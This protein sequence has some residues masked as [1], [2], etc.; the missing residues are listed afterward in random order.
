MESL[1]R[2]CIAYFFGLLSLPGSSPRSASADAI[3]MSPAQLVP[4]G[5][6]PLDMLLEDLD[7]DG[8]PDVVVTNVGVDESSIG[9][10]V[11][12]N[13]GSA[14]FASPVRYLV[15]TFTRTV[16][17]GD[18]DDDG[19]ADVAVGLI[20]E[21]APLAVL[22][23]AGDGT[24]GAPVFAGVGGGDGPEASHALD[25][26][27]DGDLD[28]VHG[29]AGFGVAAVFLNS[30]D[31]TFAAPDLYLSAN[32]A[33]TSD[34]AVAD[35]DGDADPDL[36]V[37]RTL[38]PDPPAILLNRGDGTFDPPAPFH[39]ETFAHLAIAAADVDRDGDQDLVLVAEGNRIDVFLNDGAGAFA[40]P[41]PYPLEA[42]TGL[43]VRIA[44]A[45]LD[46]DGAPEALFPSR[47][48][49][50][51]RVLRNDGA[52]AFA[53]PDQYF[54]GSEPITPRAADLDADG[55]RDVVATGFTTHQVVVLLNELGASTGIEEVAAVAGL[56]LSARPNPARTGTTISYRLAEPG[57]VKLA[58]YNVAGRVVHV[59]ADGH[60]SAGVHSASWT[61]HGMAGE[62]L[63]AGRYFVSLRARAGATI[64]VVLL[65]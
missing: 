49:L 13:Q 7:A 2:F 6:L 52:G 5:Q 24:F 60:A 30:G 4:A 14:S 38:T 44:L 56:A 63:P 29:L 18:F 8:R 41:V 65:R 47:N 42:F 46:G 58:V 35:V 61:G 33:Y 10:S 12:M 3:P 36:A 21:P 45:D 39:D 54:A 32:A 22:E 23:N 31:G 48:E 55:D 34:L 26:D 16:A 25:L 57:H 19:D 64:P 51:V 37:V 1:R 20:N 9:V 17:A 40:P 43:G 62:R 11:L 50:N 53:L 27:D 15:G 28:V 59:L